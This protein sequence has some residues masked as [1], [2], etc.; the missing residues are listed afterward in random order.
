MDNINVS[1]QDWIDY[2]LFYH[3][4]RLTYEPDIEAWTE[5]WEEMWFSFYQF[6]EIRN[7]SKPKLS[8]RIY[9]QALLAIKTLVC[10]FKR[11]T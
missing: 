1:R 7:D 6:V 4:G 11:K 9:N 2:M 3:S 8:K 5:R 10:Q